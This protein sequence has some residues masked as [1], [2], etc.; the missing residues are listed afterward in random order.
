MREPS[1]ASRTGLIEQRTGEP[2]DIALGLIGASTDLLPPAAPAGTP[3]GTLTH[4]GVPSAAQ[5]AVLSVAGHDH[6]VAALAAGAAGIDEL[7]NSTGTADV[8]ARAVAGPLLDQQRAAIVAAGWS[9]GAH[10]VPGI[11]LLL[12]GGSGGLLL[13]RVLSALGADTPTKRQH[14]DEL[15]EQV[16]ELPA[17]LLVS[18]DSRRSDEVQ[19]RLRDGAT[20][21]AVWRAATIATAQ[22]ARDMLDDIGAIV[23]PHRRAVAAGGW[24]RMA[25]VRRAKLAAIPALEISALDQPGAD[26]AALLAEYSLDSGNVPL[27]VFLNQNA[28]SL[29]A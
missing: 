22:L 12:A 21:A 28:P 17:G 3:V 26:G 13:R 11:D 6:P 20:P 14:L 25:S 8:L 1:L 7:F 24:T 27:S 9:A 18:G 5:G 4:P 23:G 10:V 29:G 15:S 2:W 16:V 19:I